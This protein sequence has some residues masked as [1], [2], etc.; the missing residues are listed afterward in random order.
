MIIIIMPCSLAG[1]L[2]Y[3]RVTR[4]ANSSE[5]VELC[6][7]VEPGAPSREHAFELANDRQGFGNAI[8]ASPGTP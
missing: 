3:A 5:D 6:Y 1:L 8:S 4:S 7:S 2:P